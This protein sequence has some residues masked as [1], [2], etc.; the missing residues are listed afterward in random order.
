MQNGRWQVRSTA[1]VEAASSMRNG[2]SR[3]YRNHY[4]SHRTCTF[5]NTTF[6]FLQFYM[7]LNMQFPWGGK[8]KRQESH[9]GKSRTRKSDGRLQQKQARWTWKGQELSF[10]ETASWMMNGLILEIVQ[11]FRDSSS[12]HL[13]RVWV[14]HCTSVWLQRPDA[15]PCFSFYQGEESM[16]NEKARAASCSR[17]KGRA[18]EE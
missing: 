8:G 13:Y 9:S 12:I 2:P 15:T 7:L 16:A 3:K 6:A 18:S 10:W 17:L 11:T 5:R 1:K 14:L 4:K